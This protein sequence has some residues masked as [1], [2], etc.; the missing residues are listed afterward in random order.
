MSCMLIKDQELLN[1]KAKQL[2][3]EANVLHS[4]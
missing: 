1:R 4:V 3:R 2:H